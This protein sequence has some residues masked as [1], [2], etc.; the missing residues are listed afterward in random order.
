MTNQQNEGLYLQEDSQHSEA[1]GGFRCLPKCPVL[2]S[3]P[4]H[5]VELVMVTDINRTK[6]MH[7]FR[8]GCTLH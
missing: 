2:D 1:I 4:V 7:W 5:K 8:H 3:V 6:W